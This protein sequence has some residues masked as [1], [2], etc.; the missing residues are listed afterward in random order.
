MSLSRPASTL[1]TLTAFTLLPQL[2][3]D[4][5]Y[6]VTPADANAVGSR[7][8]L[9][10]GKS[11]TIRD[12]FYGLFLPSGNDAAE[13]L[14]RANG[15]VSATVRQ[16]NGVADRIQ[17]GDTIAKNTSG[18]DAPGQVSS[19]YDLALVAR[20]GLPLFLPFTTTKSYD[21]PGRKNRT[22][23]IYN[24]NRLLTGGFKGAIG[25]KMGF[26]TN[27]GRTFVGAAER[28]G[29]TLIVTLMG[30]HES[31]AGAARKALKWGFHNQRKVTAVGVLVNP[32]TEEEW[33]STHRNSATAPGPAI[34][35]SP[36]PAISTAGPSFG[37]H[38]PPLSW[39]AWLLIVLVVAG[40]T[41]ASLATRMRRKQPRMRGKKSRLRA[42]QPA[43]RQF[44]D[45][46]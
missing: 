26:T 43:R 35:A 17:A 6:T 42:H 34:A 20:A 4:S 25:V 21:F 44:A 33:A 32:L 18:F 5:V 28:N 13:A 46:G 22:F 14:A 29:R 39:W 24:Q 19:A 10:P 30:I 16:M 2:N 31:S 12:L 37:I 41:A 8:G 9:I 3:L 1:K 38:I 23:T 15:S 40:L 36:P 27:A 7:V 45:I 11:Y